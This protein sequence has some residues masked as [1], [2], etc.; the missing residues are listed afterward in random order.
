MSSNFDTIIRKDL[1]EIRQNILPE[2]EVKM[3]HLLLSNTSLDVKVERVDIKSLQS[4]TGSPQGDNISRIFFNIF[5]ED[6][7]RRACCEFPRDQ[8]IIEQNGK[9]NLL[10]EIVYADNTDFIFKTKEKKSNM[11]ETVNAAFPSRN[12]K[13]NKNKTEYTFLQRRDLQHPNIEERQESRFSA[14]I[15]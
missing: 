8:A 9:S 1:T 2:D 13:E 4:N 5:L 10:K 12:L 6:S 15:F 7:I 3:P 11:I 14:R